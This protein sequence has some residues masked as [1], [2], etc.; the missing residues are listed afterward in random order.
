MKRPALLVIP[1]LL[2]GC[3]GGQSTP[4]PQVAYVEATQTQPATSETA[5]RPP[6]PITVEN[7]VPDPKARKWK[8][9]EAKTASAVR[10]ATQTALDADFEGVI[11]NYVY[12][13]GRRYR[14]VV[15]G[16][17]EDWKE[18]AD[19]TTLT[20]GQDDG[21]EPDI[22]IGG[23]PLWFSVDKIGSGI[24]ETSM[25]AKRDKVRALQRG[26]YQTMITVKCFRR[27][28]RTSLRI[29][30]GQRKYHFDLSC[31]NSHGGNG[32]N[33]DVQFTYAHDQVVGTADPPRPVREFTPPVVADTR[34]TVEGPETWRPREWAA[35]ND[36]ANTHVR[37]SPA[38]RSRPVPMLAAGSS[39]YLDPSSSEYVIAGLPS[40][41]RFPWGETAV[42]V[43]RAP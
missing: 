27:G 19:V 14:V 43:R 3:V 30:T 15:D 9:H 31:A 37:P 29:G 32:Y 10:K 36:G 42:V 18:D 5:S 11:L 17:S 13:H 22:A 8:S 20:L 6:V 25:R 39:F 28:A 21:S 40:E 4:P 23:D 16:P 34:Y 24:D 26:A 7:P 35:W 33:P 1:C 2:A 41:I 38:V 12:Q